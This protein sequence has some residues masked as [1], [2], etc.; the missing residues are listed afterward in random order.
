MEISTWSLYL[1]F[2]IVVA[3]VF[4]GCKHGLGLSAEWTSFAT[5]FAIYTMVTSWGALSV[6][7]EDG[8]RPKLKQLS[9][10]FVLEL[11]VIATNGYFLN[12]G[13]LVIFETHKAVG[14]VYGLALAIGT[15]YVFI[16]L[17][18]VATGPWLEIESITGKVSPGPKTPDKKGS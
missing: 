5:D 11:A 3:G 9:F 6:L 18:P 7:R 4:E 16:R 12:S 8:K 13:Y 17:A 1:V 10:L 14:F 15:A 2:A